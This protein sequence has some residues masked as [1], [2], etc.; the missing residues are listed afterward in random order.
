MPLHQRNVRHRPVT[1]GKTVMVMTKSPW[2]ILS[3]RLLASI[4]ADIATDTGGNN[5]CER[6]DKS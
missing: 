5:R 2:P 6:V 3:L 1:F 4:P